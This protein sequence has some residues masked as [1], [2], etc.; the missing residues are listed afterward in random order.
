MKKS[1]KSITS[2][3]L[4]LFLVSTFDQPK[5]KTKENGYK[6]SHKSKTTPKYYVIVTIER[7]KQPADR[8]NEANQPSETYCH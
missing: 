2:Q 3:I 5:K 1:T 7:P 4:H 8:M 6:E